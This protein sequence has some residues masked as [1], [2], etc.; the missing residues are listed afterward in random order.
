MRK[1]I[2]VNRH[3]VRANKKN[4]TRIPPIM[5]HTYIGKRYGSRVDIRGPSHVIYNPD[6]PLECG[7]TCWIET[8]AQLVL[9]GKELD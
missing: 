5:V 1:R 3:K 2:V 8:Y 4:G 7:A 9:D 6:K